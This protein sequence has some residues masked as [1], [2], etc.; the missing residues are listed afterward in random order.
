MM[1]ILAIILCVAPQLVFARVSWD[2]ATLVDHQLLG[3][4][5]VENVF[6]CTYQLVTGGTYRMS[7]RYKGFTCPQS[8]VVNI[9][10]GK[11]KERR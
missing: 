9:E 6:Q 10:S 2:E 8:I 3:S 11:W 1:K 7:I 4:A 5:G